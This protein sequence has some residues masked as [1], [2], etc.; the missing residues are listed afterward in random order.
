MKINEA[1][2]LVGVTKKN[3]RYYEAEGLLSPRREVGNGY[4]SYSQRDVDT[5]R[6]IKLLRKLDVPLAEVKAMLEGQ[7]SLR[8]GM[9][10]HWLLLENRQAGLPGAALGASIFL[11]LM[12]FAAA[13]MLWAFFSQPEEAPPLPVVVFLVAIPLICGA[14]VIAALVQRVKE[15]RKGEEDDYR[16]Y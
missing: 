9:A 15:I 4:R 8:E 5:L 2:S 6:R 11:A 13:L 12:I 1:E 7:L 10:R 16:N 14:G 3:I